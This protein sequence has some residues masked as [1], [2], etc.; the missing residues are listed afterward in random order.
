[1]TRF[2]VLTTLTLGLPAA[3][4]AATIPVTSDF[5]ADLDGWTAWGINTDNIFSPYLV[6]HGADLSHSASGGNPNG[7]AR[8]D[9]VIVETGA[10]LRAPA[11]FLGDWSGLIGTGILSFDH[12][13]F[14]DGDVTPDKFSPYYAVVFSGGLFDFAG[15]IGST[16][17]GPTD[18]VHVDIPLDPANWQL[19]PASSLSFE[20]IL[21]NV[22]DLFIPFELVDNDS[23]QMQEQN[24]V[25]NVSLVP[26]PAVAYFLVLGGLFGLRCRRR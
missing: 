2:I 5:D 8:F 23:V 20:Q 11:K 3:A 24:G 13:I 10:L 21:A 6:D 1:M 19:S 15:W 18:W 25:D 16:P 22:T 26:A 9:D 14:E 4:L 17:T 12:R 7:Y